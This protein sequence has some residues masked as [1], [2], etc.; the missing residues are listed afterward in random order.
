MYKTTHYHKTILSVASCC[1]MLF[2]SCGDDDTPVVPT[3]EPPEFTVKI[4]ETNRTSVD[5]TITSEKAADYAYMIAEEGSNEITSAEDLF[6]KG[7]TGIL[8]NGKADVNSKDIEGNK[9]YELYVA[10]RS[11]N[12]YV[13]S[14]VS[15][16]P[17]STDIPYTK[18][19][20]LNKVGTTDFSYHIE[21]PEGCTIKHLVVRKNDY[22]GVKSILG[23]LAEV[24]ADIYLKVFGNS[25]DTA[26]D[27][28]FDK[29]GKN[30]SGIGYDIHIHSDNT[31]LAMAGVVGEDGEIDTERFECVEFDTRSAGIASAD[32]AVAVETT[33]TA[34]SITLTPD[35]EIVSYRVLIDAKDEFDFWRREGEQQ[36]RYVIIGHWDDAT[37]SVRREYNG[38][39]QLKS[40]GLIPNKQ[41]IVGIVAFDTEGR[42]HYKEVEFVTSQPTG[43]APTLSLTETAT[44]TATPWN[45]K[46]FLVKAQNAVEVRYGF[47]TKANVDNVIN[48]GASMEAVIQ[49][50]G[51][52][53]T[54]EQLAQILSA[55][56][57]VFETNDLQP[58][59]EYVFGIY[60]RT[61]EYVTAVDYREF[62]T[63]ELPQIGGEVRKNMPGKYIASTTDENGNEVTFPVTIAT[64]VNEAT[65][66][67]Y[68]AANRLVALGFGPADKYPYMA[69]SQI[70]S[71]NPDEAYGPKW[72]IEFSEDGIKVPEVG[73]SK[74]WTMGE[75]NGAKA[76]MRGYGIRQTANGPREMEMEESFAVEVSEDGNTI[77]VKGTF[78][79]IGQGGYVYPAM[80]NPGAGWFS[81]DTYLFKSYSDIVLKRQ[82]DTDSKSYLKTTITMPKI[83]I[84]Q[85]GGGA[86]LK[87]NRQMAV[88]KLK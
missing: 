60:A 71:D 12:P 6:E 42:E 5:F 2:A 63:E 76:Y 20:T 21:V 66:A 47:W 65:T 46:A 45:S 41:Y 39:Q 52:Q 73:Y 18:L 26:Q 37:N 67:A 43:P 1:M 69:P 68:A 15:V 13:Y 75:I 36:V 48:N 72:F 25:I 57:L 40:S 61:D 24:T 53:C 29:Y 27:F 38:M 88:E 10:T 59:T 54:D 4:V 28:N 64:G 62:K 7:T 58:A 44:E 32:V 56:G 84:V 14:E 79:D 34:A 86:T 33:S 16:L 85:I 74:S 8:E 78:E 81:P 50:N 35:P 80:Y 17:L 9:N 49:S 3:P 70:S 83:S 31:F 23:G 22:E 11:I 55:D 30:A 19:L 87:E 77:T 82:P 51:N